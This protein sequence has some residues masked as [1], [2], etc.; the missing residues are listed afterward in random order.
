[1]GVRE[2]IVAE[3]T[4]V[5]AHELFQEAYDLLPMGI[6]IVDAQGLIVVVN[7]SLERL[8][9]YNRSELVGRSLECLVPKRVE[10]LHRVARDGYARHAIARPM[11]AGRELLACHRDGHE[12]PVEIGLS[13]VTRG[14]ERFVVS[15]IVDVSERRQLE[16]QL[17][18][19]QKEVAIGNLAAGIVHDFNN[20]LLSILGYAELALGAVSISPDIRSH[21]GDIIENTHRGR[22]L[23]EHILNFARKKDPVRGAVAWETIIRDSLR[24]MRVSLPANVRVHVM[25]EPDVSDVWADPVELQ[26]TFVNLVTNA[27]HASSPKGGMI[28]VRLGTRRVDSDVPDLQSNTRPEFH[29]CLSVIDEGVGMP[30]HVLERIF[31]PFFT[32]KPP[33]KGTGLGLSVIR[34]IVKALRGTVVVNSH[35]GHGT[36]VD[37]CLPVVTDIVDGTNGGPVPDKSKGSSEHSVS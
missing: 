12:I 26:Q 1:L 31:E 37:V 35:E 28:E 10:H 27:I 30:P 14:T 17:Q 34:R 11:G 25:S 18:Q 36:R 6:L 20:I 8:L 7:Q 16:E 22:D 29:V 24:L 4:L 3:H 15:T 19:V 13:P 32:T 21:L 5:V 33:G 9:G 2:E 23:V